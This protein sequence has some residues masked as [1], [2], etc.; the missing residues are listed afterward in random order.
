MSN[1]NYE[2]LTELLK[3]AF[4]NDRWLNATQLCKVF[5]KNLEDYLLSEK[6]KKYVEIVCEYN[7]WTNID[8]H[9]FNAEN[10]VLINPEF[11]TDFC[12]WLDL[13]LA[14]LCTH[15]LHNKYRKHGLAIMDVLKSFEEGESFDLMDTPPL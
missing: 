1:N 14:Y 9:H 3:S 4:E 10:E 6:F 8:T 15:H 12:F 11:N 7:N 5:N 13:E 2:N